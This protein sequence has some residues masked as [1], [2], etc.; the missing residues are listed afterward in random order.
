[1]PAKAEEALVK[2]PD[3]RLW[4]LPVRSLPGQP[5]ELLGSTRMAELLEE[6]GARFDTVLVDSP[7]VLGLPDATTLID[8]C[9]AGILV[10]S[11]GKAS[12]KDLESTLERIDTSKLL[13]TVFNGS[14]EKPDAYGSGQGHDADRR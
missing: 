4:V 14:D 12:R 3:T 6:L 11:T 7:P 1:M 13:G 5:S 8:L 10:V 2:I 9:D